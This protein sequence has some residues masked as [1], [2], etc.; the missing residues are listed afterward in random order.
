MPALFKLENEEFSEKDQEK[1]WTYTCLFKF[2]FNKLE[3]NQI[4]ITDHP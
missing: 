4:T 1:Q 2:T 3:I